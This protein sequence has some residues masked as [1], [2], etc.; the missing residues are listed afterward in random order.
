MSGRETFKRMRTIAATN[1]P[2]GPKA[3]LNS[4]NMRCNRKGECWP[5]HSLIA[6]DIGSSDRSVR[7]YLDALI[8]QKFVVVVRGGGRG[9]SNRYRL[10]VPDENPEKVAGFPEPKG[11]GNPEES[12][13]FAAD[14]SVTN[15]ENPA[16]NPE[17]PALNPETVAAYPLR[18][19]KKPSKGA[20]NKFQKPTVEQV[21]AFA[22]EN[23]LPTADVEKFWDHYESN[24]WRVG[25][26]SPMKNW[27]AAFRN[28]LRRSPEF[29][30]GASA[31]NGPAGSPE[32][33]HAWGQVVAAIR[34]HSSFEPESVRAAVGHRA[35]SAA[36]KAGGLGK[37]A[38]ANP[39]DKAK[40]QAAFTA[41]FEGA[42][43]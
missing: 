15:P 23:D 33:E 36:K 17:N 40:L 25:G 14:G 39:T 38:A 41:A 24:G 19:P 13:G 29:K 26:R 2:M 5:S 43:A 8:E 3:V 35:F 27:Q 4:L 42:S 1:L 22:A 12:A 7:T 30:R 6:R 32:A 37:I 11:A 16:L 10:N 18:T 21:R 34:E 9:L 28:W 20:R 31:G